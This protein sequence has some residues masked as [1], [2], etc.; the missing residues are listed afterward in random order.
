MAG[1]ENEKWKVQK[2]RYSPSFK[3]AVKTGTKYK[4]GTLGGIGIWNSAKNCSKSKENKGKWK[5]ER[6]V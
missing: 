1:R 6:K 3:F 4:T 2:I 5:T